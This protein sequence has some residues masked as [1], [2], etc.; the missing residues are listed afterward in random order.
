VCVSLQFCQFINSN[1]ICPYTKLKEKEMNQMSLS[2]IEVH[3]MCALSHQLASRYRSVEDTCFLNEAVVH[4]HELPVR[5]R[6]FLNDFKQLELPSG[7]CVIS[8]YP[9]DNRKIGPTPAHWKSRSNTSP[10]L[11]EEIL[12]MLFGSLLGDALAWATQQNG[13]IVHDVMP[14][15][16][17]E[18]SQLGTGSQQT[19]WWHNEDAFHPLRGDYLSLMCLRN[20]DKVPTTYGC[21]DMVELDEKSIEILFQPRFIIRPDESHSEDNRASL[22]LAGVPRETLE[23]AYR[24]ISKMNDNPEQLAVLFG[25][26]RAPYVRIDPYFMS[27][28]KDDT[29]AQAALDKL[30]TQLD[31]KLCEVVLRPGDYLFIDNYRT[32]HGRKPFRA[33]YDGND[34]WLKRINI[35]RDLRKSRN[36]R[37]NCSSRLIFS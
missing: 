14:I 21:I 1:Q 19:L 11:E 36:A 9:V 8:G 18:D 24:H 28:A 16:E 27:A 12:L 7:V 31:E 23:Y 6:R 3:D 5:V 37:M 2:D 33:K 35:S 26:P 32:V 29:E 25:D 15:R 4:A 20:P 22:E 17:N 34:R 13:Y 30:T 10:T